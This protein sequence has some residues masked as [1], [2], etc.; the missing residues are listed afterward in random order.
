MKTIK[1]VV[2]FAL[3]E[4]L[5]TNLFVSIMMVLTFIGL[6]HMEIIDELSEMGQ[7]RLLVCLFFVWLTAYDKVIKKF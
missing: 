2:L 4:N 1:N 6:G 3:S 7:F 5:I